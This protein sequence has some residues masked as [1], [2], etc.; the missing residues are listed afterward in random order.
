MTRLLLILLI[1]SP[2]YATELPITVNLIKCGET[3]EDLPKACE[4]NK[5]CCVFLEEE[6]VVVE[7]DIEVASYPEGIY[8]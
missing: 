6:P 2:A 7:V 8:E 1:S 5:A 3:K 4:E